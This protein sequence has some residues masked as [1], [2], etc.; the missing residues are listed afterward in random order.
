MD[1]TRT[2]VLITVDVECSVGT[3]YFPGGGEPV[4]PAIAIYGRLGRGQEYGIPRIMAVLEEH[5]LRGVFFT[6]ALCARYFGQI[7][8]RQICRDIATR[9]HDVQLH[10]DPIWQN[11]IPG[12][13]HARPRASDDLRDYPAEVQRALVAEG[14]NRL[15]DAGGDALCAFR[16]GNFAANDAT[17]RTLAELRIPYSSNHNA[18]IFP[19]S[20]DLRF[21]RWIND[22]HAH[23]DVYEFP[24]TC[25]A[26]RR[27]VGTHE[28]RPLQI[29]AA[30]RGELR[31]VLDQ[32]HALGMRVLTVVLH[33]FELMDRVDATKHRLVPSPK[34]EAR[35]RFLCAELAARRREYR[36]CTF[37][38]LHTGRIELPQPW[39]PE[40]HALPRSTR[41]NWFCRVAEQAASR[42]AVRMAAIRLRRKWRAEANGAIWRLDSYEAGGATTKSR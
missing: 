31:C 42:A 12:K 6:E 10:L 30:S 17:L 35:L 4:D 38:D 18:A 41:W 11:V 19:Q 28:W 13:S 24:I 33:S 20:W 27:L 2:L 16:A 32:A 25:F 39:P 34:N 8:L 36:V 9:G 7:R 40:M 15:A 22:L 26:D 21:S 5:G 14:L 37:A 1:A 3:T 29:C 23:H